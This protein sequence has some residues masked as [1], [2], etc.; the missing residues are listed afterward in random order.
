M[1]RVETGRGQLRRGGH[2]QPRGEPRM[3]LEHWQCWYYIYLQGFLWTGSLVLHRPLLLR[4]AII[5]SA[6]R[7]AFV[8][9]EAGA[10]TCRKIAREYAI[11]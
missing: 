3:N 7:S 9:R 1:G 11:G 4:A 5:V 8:L 10:H 6:I 2:V